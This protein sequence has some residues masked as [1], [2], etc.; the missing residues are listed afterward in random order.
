[1]SRQDELIEY[2]KQI[3]EFL[4]WAV[5][6]ITWLFGGYL[7]V[8]AVWPSLLRFSIYS[9]P[10][11]VLFILGLITFVSGRE[12]IGWRKKYRKAKRTANRRKS[13]I[14]ELMEFSSDE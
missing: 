9:H 10:R 5:P 14:E 11:E 6:H 2:A 12:A 1:M 7:V 13:D 8:S 4:E 3:N